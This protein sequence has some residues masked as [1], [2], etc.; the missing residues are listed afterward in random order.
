ATS[1]F[2]PPTAPAGGSAPRNGR[3]SKSPAMWTST[4]RCPAKKRSEPI[5]KWRVWLNWQDRNL[6]HFRRAGAT[7]SSCPRS[8]AGGYDEAN[9]GTNSLDELISFSGNMAEQV[10]DV[11]EGGQFQFEIAP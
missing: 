2:E 8:S 5:G 7:A 3:A 4:R 11:P 9:L 6:A 10:K 1:S